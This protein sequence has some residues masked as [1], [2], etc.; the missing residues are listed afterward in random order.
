MMP[1]RS[2]EVGRAA[3][4]GLGV[5]GAAVTRHLVGAGWDVMVIEDSPRPRTE[6]EVSAL[7]ARLG[8]VD[9]ARGVDLVVPNPGVRPGHP[10]VAAAVGAGVR[11]A[12]EIEL[13]WELAGGRPVIG[14]TGT[15]GKTTVCTLVAAMAVTD[16]RRAVAVGNIGLPFIDAVFSDAELFVVEVSSFQLYW[17]ARFRPDVGVWLNLAEDHLDWHPD[18]AHY[19]AAKAKLWANQSPGD[20]AV[21]NTEDAAVASS[22]QGARS[23][24]VGFGL[25]RGDYTMVDGAVIGPDG[26]VVTADQLP[27]HQ[28][29]DLANALAATATARAAGVSVSACASALVAFNGLPHRVERVGAVDGVAWY[30]DSKATTPASVA[31]AL[32]GFDSVVLIAGGRNKGLDLRVLRSQAS[33]LRGVV[34]IGEAA[35]EIAAALGDLVEVERAGSMAAAVDAARR[36]ARPGDVVLLS[37]GAT[38]YDWYRSYAERGDD[39]A[40]RVR[41]ICAARESTS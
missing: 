15:N 24:V 22:V 36:T 12:G 28:P 3:V 19:A 38:S 32:S 6:A 25:T 20:T 7:G 23:K 33:R 26:V 5:T 37:P 40:D 1:R 29:H 10:A 30:D 16:G 41:V 2:G 11:V 13:A 34:A 4:V 14:V 21:V 31:A 9:D 17:T 18:L 27:R 8:V 35:G 39:F